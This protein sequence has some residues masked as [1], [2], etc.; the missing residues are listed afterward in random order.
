MR[1]LV[2]AYREGV[3]GC[4]VLQD[5]MDADFQVL[6]MRMTQGMLTV[7]Y[8]NKM[9]SS[10]HIECF[11]DLFLPQLSNRGYLGVTARNSDRHQKTVEI[12]QV[13]IMNMD[14]NFYTEAVDEE[15]QRTIIDNT[16]RAKVTDDAEQLYTDDLEAFDALEDWE[17]EQEDLEYHLTEFPGTIQEEDTTEEVLYKMNEHLNHILFPLT[18]LLKNEEWLRKFVQHTDGVPEKVRKFEDLPAAIEDESQFVQTIDYQLKK[19]KQMYLETAQQAN[20]LQQNSLTEVP[21]GQ[22]LTLPDQVFS[23]LDEIH[24]YVESLQRKASLLRK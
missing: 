7:S 24:K 10:T 6:H 21:G 14:P 18:D 3:N 5:V 2:K 9:R 19:L 4:E 11:K 12:G 15:E 16:E 20:A 17:Q 8:G 23:L 1:K 13:K 22:P